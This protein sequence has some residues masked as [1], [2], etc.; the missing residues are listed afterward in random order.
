M[1]VQETS[2][3][4]T[5]A[6]TTYDDFSKLTVSKLQISNFRNYEK[7]ILNSDNKSVIITGQNGAGK[8]NILEALSL[9]S[10]GRGIRGAP[11]NTLQSI[12]NTNTWAVSGNCNSMMGESILGTG[13]G[14]GTKRRQIRINGADAKQLDLAEYMSC[15][16]LTPQMDRLFNEG[17]PSRRRFFD[18]LIL[19]FDKAHAGRISGY[20]KALRSRSQLLKEGC[21]DNVWISSLEKEI[22]ERGVAIGASRVLMASRLNHVIADGFQGFPGASIRINGVVEEW[23][24]TTSANE[25]QDLFQNALKQSRPLDAL[26]GGAYIGTHK[27]DITVQHLDKNMEASLCST[28]EQKALLIGIVLGN[29]RLQKSETG[30]M[31]ILL[32]DE[33]GAHLD[34]QK[35][36]ALFDGINTLSPQTWYTGTDLKKFSAISSDCNN[37]I[38]EE[39]VIHP[40][41]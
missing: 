25:V 13:G 1:T 2:L 31:P 40:C 17:S 5:S 32:L 8:T 23:L 20:E 26:A 16:W 28:G 6:S 11:L 15:I 41:I 24:D 12:N 36:H 30:H 18:R 37:F 35:L 3:H 21:Q 29:L 33:I 19:G 39:N 14:V 38:I 27:T 9:L 34:S 4:N 10:P 7:T 22:A